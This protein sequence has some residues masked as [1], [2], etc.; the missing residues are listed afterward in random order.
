MGNEQEKPIHQNWAM[1]EPLRPLDPE[2]TAGLS[3]MLR[4]AIGLTEEWIKERIGVAALEARVQG[5]EEENQ[6]LS[7]LAAAGTLASAMAHELRNPLGIMTNAIFSLGRSAEKSAT[8]PQKIRDIAGRLDREAERLKEI[9]ENQ[10]ELVAGKE[11]PLQPVDVNGVIREH[12]LRLS[13][14]EN[15][16]IDIDLFEISPV[17]GHQLLLGQ[18]LVN[19]ME[20][21]IQA[22]EDG[23]TLTL[24]TY[25]DKEEVHIEVQDTGRGIPEKIKD[26][27][28]DPL[29]TT[30]ETGTGLG[31][32]LSRYLVEDVM[33]GRITFTS[34]SG[35]GTTF[36][37]SLP[38]A[39]PTPFEST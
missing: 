35:E 2:E 19:L 33:G 23:G 32:A 27:I 20:N 12:Q 10:L 8:T 16:A 15:I 25:Q 26:K 3:A 18:V 14:P 9:I 13:V 31:L 36:T 22:M 7:R 39:P 4:S 28:F 29:F 24:A 21:A 5:L 34:T 30:K 37:V 11:I 38:I 17:K 6:R 1:A